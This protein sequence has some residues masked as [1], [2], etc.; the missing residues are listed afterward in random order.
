MKYLLAVLFAC[1]CFFTHAQEKNQNTWYLTTGFEFMNGFGGSVDMNYVFQDKYSLRLGASFVYMDPQFDNIPP[2]E[3]FLGIV[4]FGLST[5]RDLVSTYQLTGGRIIYPGRNKKS[6]FNLNA[7]VG[8]TVHRTNYYV[9]NTSENGYHKFHSYDNY[10]S[11]VFNP[12]WEVVSLRSVGLYISGSLVMN[13]HDTY[14]GVGIGLMLGKIRSR[15]VE[16]KDE[17]PS[18]PSK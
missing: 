16:T 10:I 11:F 18:I 14:A 1:T 6:R 5:P 3:I 12:K 17:I 8:Y 15:Q 13:K 7:G 9:E 2:E 4:T